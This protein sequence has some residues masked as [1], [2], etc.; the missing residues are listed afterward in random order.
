MDYLGIGCFGASTVACLLFS[1]IVSFLIFVAFSYT[2]YVVHT[3]R[4]M[5]IDFPEMFDIAMP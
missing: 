4:R 1:S 2:V 5:T 3:V